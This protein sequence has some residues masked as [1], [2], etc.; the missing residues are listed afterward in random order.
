MRVIKI[1]FASDVESRIAGLNG[2]G[3]AGADDWLPLYWVETEN[4]GM[5]EYKAQKRLYRFASPRTYIR[6]G[7]N[8]GC[9]ETFAC[10]ASQALDAVRSVVSCIFREWTNEDEIG[11][12]LFEPV[13][14]GRFVRKHGERILSPAKP[15]VQ[16]RRRGNQNAQ[17]MAQDQT[18]EKTESSQSSTHNP[19][20]SPLQ[21]FRSY[22]AKCPVCGRLNRIRAS[23]ADRKPICG[24]KE[25]KASLVGVPASTRDA[26]LPTKLEKCESFKS[27]DMALGKK[28]LNGE[29]EK[30]YRQLENIAI[31]MP[32]DAPSFTAT[33]EARN[34][35]DA[36]PCAFLTMLNEQYFADCMVV[37]SRQGSKDKALMGNLE[38]LMMLNAGNGTTLKI[39]C[40]TDLET[41]EGLRRCICHIFTRRDN[42][43]D[44]EC[45]KMLRDLKDEGYEFLIYELMKVMQIEGRSPILKY[46]PW[47]CS[48]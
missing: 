31:H 27:A 35:L 15:L 7:H 18:P 44:D 37:I 40:N 45:F 1:G 47:S 36:M 11:D 29:L 33:V 25:C 16:P 22:T 48:P 28:L 32:E 19:S 26:A 8:I 5:H 34:G 23:N 24:H 9:L 10:D 46:I 43:T 3:Y 14:G 30:V 41:F 6:D 42:E 12:Y 2:L 4:A 20:N 39:Q 17:P 13:T 38:S 21:A